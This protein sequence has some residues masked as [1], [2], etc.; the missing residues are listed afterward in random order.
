MVA[1]K[2]G[3]L[4]VYRYGIFYLITFLLWYLFLYIISRKGLKWYPKL[5][6]FLQTHLDDLVIYIF[7][8]VLIWG[9]LWE[10]LIY[11]LDYYLADPS[12]IFAIRDGGMSFVGWF[13][14]VMLSIFLFWYI[15]KLKLN[16]LLLIFDLICFVLPVGIFLGRRGN[17]L[18]QELYG[19]IVND[20]SIWSG[21]LD[22]LQKLDI[23]T[24]YDKID[25]NLRWNNN[26]LE[27]I[28]EWLLLIIINITFF[29]KKIIY[30]KR[31]P[32]I[33]TGV[34]CIVY[35]VVRFCLETLRDNPP[36]EYFHGLLK[37]QL[38]MIPLFILGVW[39]LCKRVK[40]EE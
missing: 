8:W 39:L 15:H 35:S 14:W 11:N 6:T 4:E 7:A 38:W 13:V 2:I 21:Y 5:A 12:K 9:R 1:F 19:K 26:L 36:N 25:N 33:V 23:A 31:K 22:V 27:M 20:G 28:L 17:H 24:V 18:N 34:F 16:T 37:S 32:G 40:V 3:G 29:L 30:T 10:V